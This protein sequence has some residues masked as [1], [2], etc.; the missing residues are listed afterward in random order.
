MNPDR[1]NALACA[2]A[3]L[4]GTDGGYTPADKL[5]AKRELEKMLAEEEQT[6]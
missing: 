1:I 4:D 3:V 6:Q 2:I 5:E